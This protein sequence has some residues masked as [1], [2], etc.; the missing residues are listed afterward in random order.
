MT[1]LFDLA[2]VAVLVIAL[3]A[4]LTFGFWAVRLGARRAVVDRVGAVDAGDTAETLRMVA[5]MESNAPSTL[6]VWRDN[7]ANWKRRRDA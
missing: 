7:Y 6:A 3:M 5:W 2:V 4:A 1:W